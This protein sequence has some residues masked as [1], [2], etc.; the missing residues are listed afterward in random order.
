MRT[1]RISKNLIVSISLLAAILTG[2]SSIEVPIGA[3]IT[4]PTDAYVCAGTITVN[5]TITYTG[6]SLCVEPGV[7]AIASI[8]KASATNENGFYKIGDQIS[9]TLEFTRD[10]VVAGIPQLMLETGTID[11]IVNYSAGSQ[12]ITLT[13]NYVV[14]E[15]DSS[16]DLEYVSTTALSLNGGS[17]KDLVDRDAEIVLPEPGAANSLSANKDIVVDG[18]IPTNGTVNDG[19]G[20]DI[21]FSGDETK[22]LFN[23]TG[24]DDASSSGIKRYFLALGTTSGGTEIKDFE[25]VGNVSNHTFTDLTL[26]HGST[27]YGTVKA[28]DKAGNV[29]LVSV[30]NGVTV[31]IYAGPPSITTI[32][33][34][35]ANVLDLNTSSTINID[36]SEP[37]GSLNL[38]VTS[39]VNTVNFSYEL[40]SQNLAISILSSLASRD[41]L[42]FKINDL[43][44]L[45]GITAADQ[46][47]TYNTAT[48]ADFNQDSNV[49]AGDLSSF[50]VAWNGDDFTKELGPSTGTV[51]NLILS[52][53]NKYDLEDVMGFTR[54][55]HW[56]RINGV[57]GKL[58]TH[59][60]EEINYTQNGSIISIDW[61]EGAAVGQFEFIYEP[62][63]V[64]INENKTPNKENVELAYV[65]TISGSNTFAYANISNNKYLNKSFITKVNGKESRPVDLIYQFYS[66]DGQ[67]IAQGS[68]SMLLKAIPEEFT[69]HQNYPNPFNPIT[70]IQYDMP[71]A[72]HV[73]LIIYDIMGREVATIINTEMNAG[74]QS[75]I[76]NT[77]NNYG[78]PVSAGIY[79][80]HL[81]TNDFVKTKKMVLVK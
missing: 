41:Q 4:I 57:N 71:K 79:F 63:L 28:E 70:T 6:N 17:I 76:W 60:G 36:F 15:G 39:T 12:S 35:V 11:S 73:R 59:F 14:K 54:M 78:R 55:W 24:F 51:P 16:P 3:S 25:D 66:I 43:K 10:V 58:L 30:T 81:Q 8:V 31:D 33:P 1:V 42:S 50:V 22:L 45:A 29:S 62:A 49:D 26:S 65:D 72:S 21:Q 38:D 9:V 5:G 47:I 80:Y 44:D 77:S 32:S 48:L 19:I 64:R 34:D 13:F 18:I 20:E 61:Q 75:I 56:S 27:Y 40:A 23:W 2:Q 74:Y 52:P 46:T 37:I 7:G 68:K 67:L 53:D 69:L